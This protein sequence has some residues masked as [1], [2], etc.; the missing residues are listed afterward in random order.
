MTL[1]MIKWYKVNILL[2]LDMKFGV[3]QGSS[4]GRLPFM[5]YM[6][7]DGTDSFAKFIRITADTIEM[8]NIY[9]IW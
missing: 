5:I 4:L 7:K 6:H 1:D 9:I 8:C 2:T 3:L